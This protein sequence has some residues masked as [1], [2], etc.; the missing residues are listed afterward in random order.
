[1]AKLVI[2]IIIFLLQMFVEIRGSRAADFVILKQK[3]KNKEKRL[4]Y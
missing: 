1:M 3:N 4:I 2:V